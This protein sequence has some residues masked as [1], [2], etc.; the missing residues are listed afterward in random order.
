ME[1]ALPDKVSVFQDMDRI[2]LASIRKGFKP[3][4]PREVEWLSAGDVAA[5]GPGLARE[6]HGWPF[7]TRA[8]STLYVPL[9]A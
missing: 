9:A 3:A 1:D 5:F 7:T 8:V 2:G 4:L 6:T